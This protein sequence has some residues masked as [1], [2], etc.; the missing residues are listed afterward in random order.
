MGQDR[1]FGLIKADRGKNTEDFQPHFLTC[2]EEKLRGE[3]NIKHCVRIYGGIIEICECIL[4]LTSEILHI[5][6]YVKPKVVLYYFMYFSVILN[7]WII[8]KLS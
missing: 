7:C 1:E 8:K 2:E 4:S 6:L 5:F 3:W